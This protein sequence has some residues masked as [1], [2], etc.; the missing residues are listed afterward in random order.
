MASMLGMEDSDDEEG[1]SVCGQG[2]GK[3]RAVSHA[4]AQTEQR[5]DSKDLLLAAAKQEIKKLKVLHLIIALLELLTSLLPH[6][7]FIL[8]P[9]SK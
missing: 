4:A 7:P 2:R 3:G 1:G 6:F 8:L 5:Q 9:W